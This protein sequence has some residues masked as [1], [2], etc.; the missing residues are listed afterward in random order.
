MIVVPVT[1]AAA[2]RSKK[3]RYY[4]TRVIDVG[5]PQIESSAAARH[6]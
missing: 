6:G 1:R 2:G 5:T 3:A 4:G